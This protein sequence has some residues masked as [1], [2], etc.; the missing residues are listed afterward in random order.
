M[1]KVRTLADS[2]YPLFLLNIQYFE[3]NQNTDYDY[4]GVC[5]SVLFRHN[6]YSIIKFL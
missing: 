6:L 2:F 3:F 5:F 1:E 4:H